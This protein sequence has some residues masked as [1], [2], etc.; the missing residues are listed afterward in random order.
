MQITKIENG[1][2]VL[3]EASYYRWWVVN[4][5]PSLMDVL[6]KLNEECSSEYE[7]THNPIDALLLEEFALSIHGVKVTVVRTNKGEISTQMKTLQSTQSWVEHSATEENL[8]VPY[9]IDFLVTLR[10]VW[11]DQYQYDI[12]RKVSPQSPS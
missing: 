5:T 3:C 6:S 11:Y 1:Q 2:R 12:G 10:S 8:Y 4:K 9:I 7:V